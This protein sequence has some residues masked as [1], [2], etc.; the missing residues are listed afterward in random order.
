MLHSI[1]SLG[2][3]LFMH[4]QLSPIIA[5]H[6]LLI[7]CSFHQVSCPCM[8]ACA[9]KNYTVLNFIREVTIVLT[10]NKFRFP[11]CW[12]RLDTIRFEIWKLWI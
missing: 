1:V 9:L 11:I 4:R 5:S 12:C 10:A 3:R 2:D 7:I 6:L 8:Y